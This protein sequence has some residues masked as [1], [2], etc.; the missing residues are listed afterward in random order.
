[1]TLNHTHIFP[2]HTHTNTLHNRHGI[3]SA[4]PSEVFSKINV[5]ESFFFFFF[6]FFFF[7]NPWVVIYVHEFNV[8]DV[9][10]A[11]C[12]GSFHSNLS[13]MASYHV[14]V[15]AEIKMFYYIK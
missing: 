9:A 14:I 12:N 3:T 1:M 2:T 6:F 7:L 4:S 11:L 15:L 13:Q 5:P 8:H 10:R